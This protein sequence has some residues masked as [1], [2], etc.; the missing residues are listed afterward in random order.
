MKQIQFKQ[1]TGQV[2]THDKLV[3]TGVNSFVSI[4]QNE[5]LS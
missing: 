5:E 3:R 1:K 4:S 2:T